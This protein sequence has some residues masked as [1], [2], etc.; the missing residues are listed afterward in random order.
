[1]GDVSLSID[2]ISRVL[3]P[4]FDSFDVTKAVLFGSYAK[5]SATVK[6]DVD[7][8]VDTDLRCFALM[9]LYCA[10]QDALGGID[11]DLFTRYELIPG[12]GRIS[13]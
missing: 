1:M 12:V 11:L 7:I 8:V 9:G 6:S 4:V 2:S 13:I 3:K 10:V 5:G